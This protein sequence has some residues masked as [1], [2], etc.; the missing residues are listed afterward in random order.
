MSTMKRKILISGIIVCFMVSLFVG[1]SAQGYSVE[2]LKDIENDDDFVVGP[3]KTEIRMNAG[4]TS[5]KSITVTN[6]YGA[7]MRFTLVIEDFGSP[8]SGNDVIKLLGSE[9]GPY[10]LRDY[11][12][13]DTMTFVLQHG[14]RATIPVNVE[15]PKDATPGGLYG[16]V[17]VTTESTDPLDLVR[18]EEVSGG[19]KFVSRV[20]SLFFVR[21]N[22]EVKEEGKVSE[23]KT[24]KKWYKGG[25]VNFSWLYQNTGNVY[26]NPF[27]ILE[28]KNLYGTVVDQITIN[29]YFVMPSSTRL[30]EKTWSR[31]FML[32]R[33]KATLQLNR[34]YGDNI[35]TKTIYFW[36][37][38]W[39][40]IAIMLV[41]LFLILAIIRGIRRWFKRNF[42]YKGKNKKGPPPPTTPQA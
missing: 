15:I 3:G 29:P 24:G 23:F 5:T 4:E 39:K 26:N 37:L 20:A 22:G 1:S 36:V 14:D 10:S 6:R 11:L 28:I 17:I 35:D 13:P 9:K 19:L 40:V 8:D 27:G 25:P 2:Q 38:P 33:Y 42:E 12:K 7:E 16:A 41:G 21:I 30:T 34:G 18:E 31:D 32:G